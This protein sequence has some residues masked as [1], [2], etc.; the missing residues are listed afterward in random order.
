MKR[1]IA[2]FLLITMMLTIPANAVED[3]VCHEFPNG[4][5]ICG[6]QDIVDWLLWIHYLINPMEEADC[7]NSGDF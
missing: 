3:Y 5:Y 4:D 6:T 7:Q 1:I 2:I